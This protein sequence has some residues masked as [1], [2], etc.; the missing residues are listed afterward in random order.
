MSAGRR[1]LISALGPALLLG[2]ALVLALLIVLLVLGLSVTLLSAALIALGCAGI[3]ET[4]ARRRR[5]ID[6]PPRW[7]DSPSGGR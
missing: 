5:S 4:A 6:A 3:A 2:A 7:A 1:A